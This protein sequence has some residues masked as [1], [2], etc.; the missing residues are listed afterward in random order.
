M[1]VFAHG[2]RVDA[3]HCGPWFFPCRVWDSRV[4]LAK[5]QAIKAEL[6]RRMHEPVAAVGAW[7]RKVVNGFECLWATLA[8]NVVAHFYAAAVKDAG[9]GSEYFGSSSAGFQPH[10]FRILIL[11]LVSS[12]LIQGGSRMRRS[13]GDQ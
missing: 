1:A 11:Q 3:R 10:A 2:S 9:R 4:G 12:Q 13:A 6:R 5:L 7:L 8:T